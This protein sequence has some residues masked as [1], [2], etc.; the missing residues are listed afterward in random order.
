MNSRSGHGRDHTVFPE[1]GV[2]IHSGRDTS[3]VAPKNQSGTDPAA[4][5]RFHRVLAGWAAVP[6]RRRRNEVK[7]EEI[8]LL[9]LL[10]KEGAPPHLHIK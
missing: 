4:V 7:G 3:F 9:N 5:A 10:V 1:I 2:L 8:H 6:S